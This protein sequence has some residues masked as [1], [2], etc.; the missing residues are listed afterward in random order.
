MFEYR[1]SN[2]VIPNLINELLINNRH[3]NF[4]EK[5]VIYR[6]VFINNRAI[7]DQLKVMNVSS[8]QE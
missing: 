3:K 2:F 8:S 7:D 6:Y 4:L 5:H 1:L